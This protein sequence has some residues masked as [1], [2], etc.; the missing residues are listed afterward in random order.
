[1]GHEYAIKVKELKPTDIKELL[2]HLSD[3]NA[4][5]P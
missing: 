3:F 5:K 1:M 4:L 2:R